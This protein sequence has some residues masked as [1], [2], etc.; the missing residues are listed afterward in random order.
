[1]TLSDALSYILRHIRLPRQTVR[2]ISVTMTACLLGAA[3]ATPYAHALP[4]ESYAAESVLASG[5]WA[6]VNVETTGMQLITNTQLKNLG[7]NDPDKVRVYGYGGAILPETLNSDNPDDLPPVPSV[8]TTKGIVFFG[9]G[10]ER[11]EKN[12]SGAMTYTHTSNPY[13]DE[14]R[15]F[16]S[17]RDE[18][19]FTPETTDASPKGGAA[20]TSF[21][22]RL[23]HEKDMEAAG[24]Y[25]RLLLG[26][27]FR[28]QS[29]KSFSF[30]LPDNIGEDA[31]FKT[32][33]GTKITSGQ[34]SLQFTANGTELTAASSD[35]IT[36]VKDEFIKLTT[37]QKNVNNPGNKLDLA[38]KFACSGAL[39]KARL[40]FIEVEYER[41]LKLSDG[42]LYFYADIKTPSDFTLEGCS[43]ETVIWDITDFRT[44]KALTARREGSKA[45]FHVESTGYREYIAF[46]P[47]KVKRA[48]TSPIKVA[49]QNIHAMPAPGM[50][51]ISPKEYMSAAQRIVQLHAETDGLD[52]MALTPEEIYNEFSSGSPDV[53]AFRK[54]LK[55]WYDRAGKDGDYTRYC[56]I[57][58]RPTYDNKMVTPAVRSAG[59][60]RVPIWHSVETK[61][62]ENT[63]YSTDDY[64]GMLDDNPSRFYIAGSKIHVAVGR[65]PVK[66]LA[67]AMRAVDK[68]E[69]YIKEPDLGGWRNNVMIIA[70]DQDN[71]THLKQ[72]EAV[73]SQFINGDLG[74]DFLYERLYLDSYPLEFSGKGPAYPQAKKRLFQKINDGVAYIDYIGHGNPTGLT[75]EGVVNWTDIISMSNTR[76]PFIFAATCEFMR[77]DD[78]AVSGAEELWLNPTAG[79]IGMICPSRT[80]YVSPNGVLN[81]NTASRTFKSGDDGLPRRIGDIYIAGKNDSS[82]DNN[83][84]FAFMGDPSMRITSINYKVSVDSIA[85]VGLAEAGDNLPELAARSRA[86]ASGHITDM[87]GNPV[88]DFN[89]TAEIT[90]F[91][92]ERIITTNGNGKDGVESVYN[93]RKTLLFTGQCVVENG[94]WE[95]EMLLP[96]EIENNYSPALLNIYASSDDMRE[97]SGSTTDFYVYGYDPALPDDVDGPEITRFVLNNDNFTDGAVVSPS[98]VVIADFNDPSGINISN[99]GIGHGISLT[100]DGKEFID[101]LSSYFKSDISDVTSGRLTYPLSGIGAGKHTLDLTVWDNANNSST[102][103]I[104]FN[105]DVAAAPGITEVSTDVNPARTSV[106]FSVITDR[107]LETLDCVIEVFDL[108]GGLVWSKS[109]NTPTSS[110]STLRFGWNLTDKSG[111]RVPRGIYLYRATVTSANGAKTSKTRKLAVTAP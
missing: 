45:T 9:I 75:H 18:S 72:G 20:V 52:V 51:L 40:D 57:M 107:A 6:K 53:T 66:N 26:E 99:S 91:D 17:D 87:Q 108:S 35:V 97:A 39:F 109:S 82:T 21:T 46:D 4:P 93:D 50:L 64:I 102:A 101:N 85:G 37:I 69:K 7:F 58:S 98:P 25:G 78:D 38:I 5:K 55:M 10:T 95:M 79:V 60:P 80:V 54:L 86:K 8:R 105:V 33:F 44:P 96:S 30:P 59:Y 36:N 70:D 73:Y 74:K 15:Y 12:S 77:W 106:V 62:D 103:R 104:E 94:K 71:G 27:D 32:R 22:C 41:A 11:W 14:S 23:L 76:L 19:A 65:M 68:L 2:S 110:D 47:S 92:A 48:V 67:E 61:V 83:L 43:D 34:G 90:L 3:I 63:S 42:E 29:T 111:V 88:T 24:N 56:L 28:V 89:G 81:K 31:R 13:S 16:I 100:V 49:N 84:K 1:M